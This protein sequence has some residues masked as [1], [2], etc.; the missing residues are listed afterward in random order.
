MRFDSENP[1]LEGMS[2]SMATADTWQTTMYCVLGKCVAQ[3]SSKWQ[4]V[5]EMTRFG[6]NWSRGVTVSILD[7]ESSDRGSNPRETL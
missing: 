6:F 5:M 2:K 1:I 7:S 3:Y 4:T